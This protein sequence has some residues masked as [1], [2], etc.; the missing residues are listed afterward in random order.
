M[1]TINFKTGDTFSLD[2]QILDS[3]GGAVDL[4]GLTL[5]S[6][7]TGS[8]L[9]SVLTVTVTNAATGS[10]N[11]SASATDTST[12]PGNIEG[13]G[14]AQ[15]GYLDIARTDGTVVKHSPTLRVL[16]TKGIA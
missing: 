12:W 1:Q 3:N 5:T 13:L 6:K 9:S 16:M 11:L 10:I 4:S 2:C 15:Y 8:G 14:V 7:I